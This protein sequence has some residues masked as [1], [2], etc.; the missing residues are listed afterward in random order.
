M[1]KHRQSPAPCPAVPVS[2]AATALPAP[3]MSHPH[4][5]DVSVCEWTAD[6]SGAALPGTVSAR[7]SVIAVGFV[8]FDVVD[9][10]HE[11]AASGSVARS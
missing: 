3:T 8:D 9:S 11:T 10:V 7:T 6:L 1:A 2:K 4:S 5:V